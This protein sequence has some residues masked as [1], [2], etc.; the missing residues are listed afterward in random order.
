M[1]L[2]NQSYLEWALIIIALVLVGVIWLLSQVLITLSKQILKK[3]KSEMSL[4]SLIVIIFS[5]I[6]SSTASAQESYIVTGLPKDTNYGGMGFIQFYSM[7]AV[8]GIELLV[9][10]YLAL[11]IRRSFR[12]LSGEADAA[13]AK[14]GEPSS[15][16]KWWHDI[17][18]KWMTQAI[19][20]EKEA[21][22]LLD[23][24]YDGI[25]ELDNSLPPWWKYGFYFTIVVGAI[26]LFN[27]HVSGSGLNPDQEYAVEME[28]GKKQEE[29]YKAKTKDLVDENNVTLADASGIALGKGLYTQSC[30][31]C[32]GANGEGGIGPNLTDEYWLHGGSLNDIYKTIK[33]G[34]PEKGMQAWQSMYRPVQIKQLTSYVRSLLGTKPANPKDPQG[35]IYQEAAPKADSTSLKTEQP[36]L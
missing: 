13:L 5:S 12:E 36:V 25:K 2:N 29:L 24:D 31:A 19:P 35:S 9:I 22:V 8:I 26:Y 15:L 21:D 14:A 3:R 33:I 6:L 18:K 27:Y 11:M 7:M 1:S 10:L 34:Y 30:V 32:H 28:A 23:H 4:K 20:I 17:D 16:A